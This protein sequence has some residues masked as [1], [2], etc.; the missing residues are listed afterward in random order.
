MTNCAIQKQLRQR[1][2]K[3]VSIIQP[4]KKQATIQACKSIVHICQF[5]WRKREGFSISQGRSCFSNSQ[6]TL[7]LF[8]LLVI[9]LCTF[10]LYYDEG[11]LWFFHAIAEGPLSFYLQIFS[12]GSKAL[13]IG[14]QC[15]FVIYPSR[16][17][18][19]R[20]LGRNAEAA[21]WYLIDSYKC[22]IPNFHNP[23]ACFIAQG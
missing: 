11:L 9:A 7:F 8:L 19:L 18:Y 4:Q 21:P 23:T 10:S 5:F 15:L 6:G 12:T 20:T 13:Q 16:L 1:F 3:A 14:K 17:N 22:Y 2:V